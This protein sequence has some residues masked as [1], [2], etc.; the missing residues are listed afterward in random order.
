MIY[1][2]TVTVHDRSVFSLGDIIY[3]PVQRL[4]N[5]RTEKLIYVTIVKTSLFQ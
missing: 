4:I 5:N 2:S 1:K 3:M